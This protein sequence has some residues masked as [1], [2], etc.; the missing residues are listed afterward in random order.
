[1]SLCEHCVKGVTHSGEPTGNWQEINGVKSYIATP[2]QD[3]P[4]DKVLLY[5]T[6]IFGPQLVNN[7][8]LADDYAA[9]GIKTI[10]PDIFHGDAAPVDALKPGSTWDLMAWLKAHGS[11]SARPPI[12]KVI[13]GLK[14]D[15]VTVF[16]VV[17]YCFGARFAFDLAFEGIPKVVAIAHPSLVNVD[18]DLQTYA[19]KATAP[20][21]VNSCSVDPKFPLEA[22]IKADELFGEG[23]FA[24]GYKREHWEGCS[25]GFAVRGDI[26]DSKVKAG[27][28]GA[29][30]ASVEW[31]KKYL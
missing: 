20:L 6:D 9:N 5:I 27:K 13:E 10:I 8:L 7:R 17:G 15:G 23:K 30:K 14:N 4:K 18:A 3:Y 2:S 21:L 29:F 28:E 31:I 11:D 25:H 22:Q 12:D 1:M 19:T 26:S 24:P 16:A